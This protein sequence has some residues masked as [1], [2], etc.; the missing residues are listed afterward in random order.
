[1]RASN[2]AQQCRNSTAC[3]NYLLCSP[4][5]LTT[6]NSE[7]ARFKNPFARCDHCRRRCERRSARVPSAP[8]SRLRSRVTLIEK[9]QEVGRALPTGPPIR[10]TAHVRAA[11]MSASPISPTISGAGYRATE[12]RTDAETL[13]CSDPFCF[14]PRRVYGDTSRT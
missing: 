14:V 6:R 8:R 9:R 13:N 4:I 1:V 10:S 12:S 5:A 3:G 2:G 7:A 11:N